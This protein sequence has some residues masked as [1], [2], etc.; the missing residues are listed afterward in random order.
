MKCLCAQEI[1]YVP[2]S[3]VTIEAINSLKA[4][5]NSFFMDLALQKFTVPS[6]NKSSLIDSTYLLPT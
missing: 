1:V 2:P 3:L 5:K 4:T 6:G